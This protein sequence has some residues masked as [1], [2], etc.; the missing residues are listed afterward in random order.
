MEKSARDYLERKEERYE[1][2]SL[3]RDEKMRAEERQGGG[4]SSEDKKC[5]ERIR[6]IQVSKGAN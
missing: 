2:D 6:Y 1:K 5:S 4:G 3:R